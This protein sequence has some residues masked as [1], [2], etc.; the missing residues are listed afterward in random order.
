MLED[1]MLDQGYRSDLKDEL[2]FSAKR[3]IARLGARV[4]IDL[5]FMSGDKQYLDLGVDVDL[6]STDPFVAAGNLLQKVTGFVPVRVQGELNWYSQES[7]YPLSYLVGN[8]LMLQLKE[9]FKAK[10]GGDDY[11]FHK[12]ILSQGKLPLAYF[13]V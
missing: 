2:R 8:H 6:S 13:L 3:D 5:F 12:Y 7:G 11:S 1:Y 9:A 4:A 10:R